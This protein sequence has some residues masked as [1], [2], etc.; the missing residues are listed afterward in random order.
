[1][2]QIMDI[3]FFIFVPQSWLAYQENNWVWNNQHG[4]HG[5]GIFIAVV[6]FLMKVHVEYTRSFH[7]YTCYTSIRRFLVKIDL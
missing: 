1:M 3:I 4:M 6:V 5:F 2:L 7:C